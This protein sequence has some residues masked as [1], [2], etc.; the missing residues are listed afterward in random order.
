M[1]QRSDQKDSY[2][3]SRRNRPLG[4]EQLETRLM[5]AVDGIEA[6]L[7]LLAN[8]E[9]VGSSQVVGNSAPT[10]QTQVRLASG[11]EVRGKTASASVLGADDKPES[12]L[13]YVWRATSTPNGGQVLFSANGTNAAKKSNLTFNRAG[14]YTLSVDIFDSNGAFTTSTLEFNVVQVLTSLGVKSADGR[15]VR[16]NSS[17]SVTETSQQLSV[18]AL[19]Q[20]GQ[21]MAT[22]PSFTWESGSV[23]SGATCTLTPNGSSVNVVMSQSGTYGLRVRSGTL[24]TNFSLRAT[25]VFDAIGVKLPDGSSVAS[26]QTVEVLGTSQRLSLSVFDQFGKSIA[27]NSPFQW[28]TLSSP[29]GSRVT[30]TG[31]GRNVTLTFNKLGEYSF[32]ISNGNKSFNLS[33][34]VQPKLTSAVILRENNQPVTAGSS[35]AVAGSQLTVS[36]RG[37]DQFGQVMSS[38]GS[39]TWTSLVKPN[40]AN[41]TSSSSGNQATWTF[42]RAGSYTLRASSGTVGANVSVTVTQVF[43]S[44]SVTPGTATVAYNASQQ[45][46]VKK[47]DQ[48]QREMTNSTAVTWSATGGTITNSGSFVAGTRS[49]N[50]AVT[51]RVG[52]VSASVNIAVEAPQNNT[53]L[54]NLNLATLVT[55]LYADQQLS[56]AEMIQIL[57]SAGNDGIVD[58]TELSDL[59]YLVSSNSIYAMPGYVRELAKDVVNSNPANQTFRGQAAG[60][61]A[62]GSSATL[63]NNLVN[64]WF[65]GADEPVI[66]GSGLSYQTVVGNLFNGTPSRSDTKQGQLGDCYFIASVAAI[67]DRNPDAVRNMFIDNGDGTYTVRFYASALGSGTPTADYVTV[68]R[69]LPAYANGTLGYSGYGQ[70]ISSSSTTL[71]IALA[72]KAYAQWNE[73]G[74]EGRDGTNRYAAIEGGWMSNVNAQVLGYSSTNYA[75]A[76]TSKQTLIDAL[77]NNRSTTLGTIGSPNAGGLVGSHAYIVYAYNSGNDT[78]SLHNPWGT[79]HPTALSWAQLQSN[80]SYFVVTD[81]T[82]SMAINTAAVRSMMEE[83]LVGSWTT[84]VQ[85]SDAGVSPIAYASSVSNEFAAKDQAI[86]DVNGVVSEEQLLME[87]ESIASIANDAVG[88]TESW[89]LD[90]ASVDAALDALLAS[91]LLNA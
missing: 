24:S 43:T 5:N 90:P 42:D 51:A 6:N 13:R 38:I 71:W 50:F 18:S 39:L 47:L 12:Q 84:V 32:Q 36:V 75:F 29:S 53:N 4:F 56:R 34:R 58:A 72:E 30:T 52:T 45:F 89:S 82:Q 85:A 88:E 57:Q 44:L 25:P 11:T 33:V 70:S 31:T 80:C 66:S 37:L 59:R 63:L 8:L 61:L 21:A 83:A 86:S 60:N 26:G 79:S 16:A 81:P 20:F 77:N 15:D 55:T 1:T 35:I 7:Q 76:N 74:N 17:L 2:K 23:P 27:T 62:A 3:K 22:Q 68:N 64:K 69:R 48:F 19:D 9:N 87:V 49:G 54:Q 46:T 73:T 10:V 28:K 91:G 40:G 14:S 67:A 65:L 41:P 78:F